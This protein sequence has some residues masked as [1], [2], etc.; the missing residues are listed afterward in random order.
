MYPCHIPI[1]STKTTKKKQN[2]FHLTTSDDPTAVTKRIDVVEVPH[3][4]GDD[5]R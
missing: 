5:L 3:G 4:V 1:K 2:D